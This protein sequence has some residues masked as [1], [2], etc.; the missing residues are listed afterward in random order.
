[1]E[2]EY[3]WL[4][5]GIGP[6]SY[7]YDKLIQKCSEL[8]S[9]HYGT[10][11]QAAPA[12][13]KKGNSIKLS[14][15][16]IFELLEDENSSIYYA[17][18]D[19]ELLGYAI[20]IKINVQKKGTISWV[21]QLVVRR[22]YRNRDIAKNLLSSIWGFTNDYAWGIITANPYAIRALEKTTR[23]RADPGRIERNIKKLMSIA[24]KHIPYVDRGM[25]V[26][27]T[28]SHSKVNTS[29][30]VDHSSVQ[31]MISDVVTDEKPWTLG[32]ID[33][34]WEWIAFTFNDQIPFRISSKELHSFLQAS[35]SIVKDAYSRMDMDN[36]E[37]KW[38]QNAPTE[39]DY[40]IHESGIKPGA[41]II[42]FGCGHGRHCIEFAKKGYDCYG[43]D[44][45]K[46]KIETSIAKAQKEGIQN[47]HFKC[48]DCRSISLG[49]E[50]DVVICLYDVIGT[51]V[52]NAENGRILK[53]IYKHVKPEG[54]VFLTV[55][56]YESTLAHAKYVFDLEKEP[57]KLLEIAPSN[58]MEKSGNIFNSDYYL[59]DENAHT[60]YRREQFT[61]GT[62]M[63][64]EFI[65][66]DRRFTLD[67]IKTLCKKEGLVVEDCHCV[68]SFDWVTRRKPDDKSA[69]EILIKCRKSSSK[70]L[71][72]D[73]LPLLD[74]GEYHS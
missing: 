72:Y 12:P 39:V 26:V 40:I 24:E 42:D 11:S 68:N 50:A 13:L 59:V 1:M 55:M 25:E 43:I 15:K 6:G 2:I 61:T 22:E 35:D 70:E 17:I 47:V 69:K 29:F 64:V 48:G 44:Y 27:V 71:L 45:I 10:W 23:R 8:Y 58:T 74:E 63:P 4:C 9:S 56:N 19:N 16:R 7:E 28:S 36:K 51:Y 18:C 34:G 33:E 3:K 53:N 41:R 31:T 73:D 52:D 20:A 46:K 57:G 14:T 21:T 66:R 30:F 49:F 32:S 54:L 37:Q 5:G 67:E 38:A 62:S 60:I 65:V